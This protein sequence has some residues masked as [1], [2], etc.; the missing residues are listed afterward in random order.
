MNDFTWVFHA[1]DG[2]GRVL[3][4]LVE[5]YAHDLEPLL[6]H[7]ESDDPLVRLDAELRAES[8]CAETIAEEPGLGRFFPPALPDAGE[9]GQFRR[10]AIAGQA[11]NR[12]EAARKVLAALEDDDQDRV[13]VPGRDIDSW[14]SVLAALRAQWHVE[15]TGS[16]ERLA[17]PTREDVANDPETAAILDWLALLIEDALHAKWRGDAR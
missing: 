7:V 5:R 8:V 13:L 17:E 15:L 11:Q 16:S 1:G 3:R 9:V 10:H 2:R 4:F 14:V 6:P 12:L